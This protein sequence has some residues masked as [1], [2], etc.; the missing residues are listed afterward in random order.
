MR[1][2]DASP[3]WITTKYAAECA[4][5]HSLIQP[6]DGAKYFPSSRPGFM[7]LCCT[8]GLQ[9]DRDLAAANADDAAYRAG[10]GV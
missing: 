5:C 2:R 4:H 7:L 6:Q 3:R 1:R 8:C 9:H 10:Y